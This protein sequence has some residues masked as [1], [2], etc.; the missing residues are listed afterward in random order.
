MLWRSVLS[1]PVRR[2]ARGTLSVISVNYFLVSRNFAGNCKKQEKNW[3]MGFGKDHC[4]YLHWLICV[5]INAHFY[6]LYCDSMGE[7]EIRKARCLSLL[8]IEQNLTNT[9]LD[10]VGK[11]ANCCRQLSR[12]LQHCLPFLFL[13]VWQ[14]YMKLTSLKK[15]CLS[16]WTFPFNNSYNNSS[17]STVKRWPFSARRLAKRQILLTIWWQFN[18][19]AA[20]DEHK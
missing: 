9:G 11:T 8:A 2:S 7:S 13:F 5:E 3:K 20:F 4:S 15:N 6:M 19:T 10:S 14:Q 17:N 18:T 1:R 16:A 12:R